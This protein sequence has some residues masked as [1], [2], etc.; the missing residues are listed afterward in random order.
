M[1]LWVLSW[2]HLQ[3]CLRSRC[4]R[5]VQHVQAALQ[6]WHFP[7]SWRGSLGVQDFWCRPPYFQSTTSLSRALQAPTQASS[8]ENIELQQ[9]SLPLRITAAEEVSVY[10]CRRPQLHAWEL[11]LN[12][13]V[14][15]LLLSSARNRLAGLTAKLPSVDP[16]LQKAGKPTGMRLVNLAVGSSHWNDGGSPRT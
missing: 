15:P 16:T 5:I 8:W 1:D 6:A 12:L 2:A 11:A 4:K 9:Y 7:R 3:A 14:R 13:S 10:L